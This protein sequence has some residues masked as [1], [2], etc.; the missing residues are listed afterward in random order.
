MNKDRFLVNVKD[1]LMLFSNREN[2]MSFRLEFAVANGRRN[3]FVT[4][5]KRFLAALEM[6]SEVAIVIVKIESMILNAHITLCSLAT[7]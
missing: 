6:T 7:E 2:Q 4:F 3:L 1:E 5:I